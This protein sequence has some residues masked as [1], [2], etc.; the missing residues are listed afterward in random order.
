MDRTLILICG[1]SAAGKAQ[2][3][4]TK[5]PTPS[6]Y[7]LL[8]DLRVGDI[9]YGREGNPEY[10]QDIFPQGLQ[11]EYCVEFSDGRKA[12]THAEHIWTCLTSR[13]NFIN[14]TTIEMMQQGCFTSSGNKR[15]YIPINKP[16]LYST[17]NY[18]IHP[19]IVGAFIGDG[20]CLKK[21]L[22]IS[23][24]DEEIIQHISQLLPIENYYRKRYKNN[25]Y[26]WFF[27][28]KKTNHILKTAEIFNQNDF[29]ELLCYSYQK[30]IPSQ[31]LLGDIEQRYCLL[32]GLLDTDGT[33]SI[34]GDIRYTTTSKKLICSIQQLCWSLGLKTG[35]ICVDSRKEKY[36]K[37]C[38]T[39]SI[40][41]L[42][43]NK[44]KMFF[45]TRK[46]QRTINS[47][48]KAKYNYQQLYITNIYA[49]GHKK[50]MTCILV[51]HKEHLYLTENYIVTHNTTVGEK[52]NQVLQA[53][54]YSCH[55]MV[56]DTTRPKR[57]GE[58]DGVHYHFISPQQFLQRA[59]DGRYLEY[60]D[61]NRWY[62][63]TS[64]D[65]IKDGFNITICDPAGVRNM[66]NST[67]FTSV[68]PVLLETGL[69]ERLIRSREREGAWSFEF[70]RR[71]AADYKDFSGFKQWLYLNSKIEPIIIH[72]TGGNQASLMAVNCI[73]HRLQHMGKIQ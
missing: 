29:K 72:N 15:F 24:A 50:N 64:A 66:I 42:R 25:T 5:I 23:S 48:S 71:A 38:Y 31:Y 8:G 20:C 53:K 62:Y 61:F 19:Y 12:Y 60:T 13:G 43:E 17:K 18:N 49:T 6:G 65:E 33:V 54:N 37:E 73:L 67:L 36:T 39:I 30:D 22:T 9:V 52:L 34:K 16:V 4:D 28:D 3:N 41:A 69:K 7:K 45:L 27:I 58:I 10:I 55:M 63:G 44:Q 21:Y 68:L 40:N 51:D 57:K 32:Q 1:K 47:Q 35:R 2:P 46:K 70:I 26:D 14:R 11:D 59:A 56:S